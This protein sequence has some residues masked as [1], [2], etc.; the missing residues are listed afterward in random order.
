[1]TR[2]EPDG[3]HPLVPHGER[4]LHDA[5]PSFAYVIVRG[6][7][8]VLPAVVLWVVVWLLRGLL[9]TS[10]GILDP[11]LAASINGSLGYVLI[12]TVVYGVLRLIWALLD[13]FTRRYVLSDVRLIAVHGVIRTVRFD[14]PLRR[15]QHLAVT[16]SFL[17][18][19]FRVGTVSA[20]TA[21][22][23]GH[24]AVW[25]SVAMPEEA[26]RKVSAR[27]DHVSRRGDEAEPVPVIG[28]VGGIGSGKSAAAAAFAKVGC[29]VSDSDAA[30]RKV[31]T[32]PEV[33]EQ[34]SSWWGKV[35]LDEQ[36]G[37]DRKKIADLVFNDEYERRRLE[38]VVHPLV[39]LSR[40]ALVD[41]AR[42]AGATGVVVDA[43]LLFEAGV[44]AECDSVVFVETPRS[45][46]LSRVRETR[47]WAES[48]LD[49]REKAQMPL[50][51]KRRRS[52][53]VLVNHGTISELESRAANLLVAIRKQTR[54]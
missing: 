34:L 5:R 9:V 27:T 19:L 40:E 25:R 2:N 35:V 53:H 31:L 43:P 17:E 26:L 30:V 12:F 6:F 8:D 41:R 49:R 54:D 28:L 13:W 52:D 38:S 29:V 46:R 24:E 23:D 21:G 3:G 10:A 48:E 50:E 39:R 18:R 22:T 16:R 44:D 7:P 36:G 37:L 51:E 15:V 1:M 14:V 32:Q 4:V 45:Q 20:A 33:I 42:R 11:A 47:G